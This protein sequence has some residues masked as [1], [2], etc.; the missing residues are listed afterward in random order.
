MERRNEKTLRQIYL[1]M[2]RNKITDCP[3]GARMV[4]EAGSLELVVPDTVIQPRAVCGYIAHDDQPILLEDFECDES[5]VDRN[6]IGIV[7]DTRAMAMFLDGTDAMFAG[8]DFVYSIPLAAP[9]VKQH[10]RGHNMMME[11]ESAR[12]IGLMAQLGELGFSLSTGTTDGENL[13]VDVRAKSEDGMFHARFE[14]PI[15]FAPWTDFTELVQTLMG[16]PSV[17]VRPRI[18]S[19]RT[20]LRKA[21]D[22]VTQSRGD[23]S[24]A[25]AELI[26]KGGELKVRPLERVDSAGEVYEYDDHRDPLEV[27][28]DGFSGSADGHYQFFPAMLMASALEIFGDEP[29]AT[30]SVGPRI[31]DPIVLMKDSI[32]FA[33]RTGKRV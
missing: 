26:V 13:L 33:V 8:P 23:R 11:S 10:G 31:G 29:T 7:G 27:K 32:G 28:V 5:G 18:K 4:G 19:L 30:V 6:L 2:Q 20:A 24:I 12:I 22:A 16:N 15:I 25:Y 9:L 21:T 14:S 1:T 17:V 3:N